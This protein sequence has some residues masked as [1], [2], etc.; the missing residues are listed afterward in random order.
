LAP[1]ECVQV[2]CSAKLATASEIEA[3]ADPAGTLHECHEQNNVSRA[4][5]A[6]CR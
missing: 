3:D 2:S 6:G 5:V 1:G 4:V